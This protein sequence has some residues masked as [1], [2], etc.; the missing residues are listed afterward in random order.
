[1]SPAEQTD[2][3]EFV[4]VR[5][6]PSER[7]ALE[8]AAEERSESLSALIRGASLRQAR[9]ALHGRRSAGDVPARTGA[10]DGL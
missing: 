5:L 8:D 6:R 3:T 4:T 1:M 10:P 2:R 9:R 7:R